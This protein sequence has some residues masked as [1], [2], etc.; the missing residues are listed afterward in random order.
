MIVIFACNKPSI[1][2]TD[3]MDYTVYTVTPV[4][5]LDALIMYINHS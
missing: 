1:I 5:R 2:S 3:W 4:H